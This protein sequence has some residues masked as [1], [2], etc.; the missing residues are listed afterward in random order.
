MSTGLNNIILQL[1]VI[2]V[3]VSASCKDD[4]Y[5][6]PSTQLFQALPIYE[7]Q[8]LTLD[9]CK[10]LCC[11]IRSFECRSISMHRETSDCALF[12]EDRNTA[13]PL[14]LSKVGLTCE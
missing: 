7:R 1:L 6:F 13:P 10:N 4:F 14:G 12:A 11:M 9:E 2:F 5:H 3:T 8:N